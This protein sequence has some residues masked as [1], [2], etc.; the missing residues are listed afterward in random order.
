MKNVL[1]FFPGALEE[2]V[3]YFLL[4]WNVTSKCHKNY[5]LA[6][7]NLVIFSFVHAGGIEIDFFLFLCVLF[8]LRMWGILK[9]WDDTRGDH[10]DIQI[11]YSWNLIILLKKLITINYKK[12]WF[13]KNYH[14][15]NYHHVV[16]TFTAHVYFQW[17]LHEVFFW[18]IYV[19][20][21]IVRRN[22]SDINLLSLILKLINS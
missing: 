16:V 11:N 5:F 8:C 17:N 22:N 13:T 7:K 1:G 19:S 4:W 2:E 21:F 14:T 9:F 15:F 3:C 18:I 10:S 20:Y 6:C 12:E